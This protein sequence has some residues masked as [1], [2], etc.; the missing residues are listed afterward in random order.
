MTYLTN[1]ITCQLRAIGEMAC[2]EHWS[3]DDLRA[4]SCALN[5][6]VSDIE[7]AL[8]RRRERQRLAREYG[9]PDQGGAA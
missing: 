6:A 1:A 2:Q 4:I 5:G 9:Y 3:A 7:M 8:A